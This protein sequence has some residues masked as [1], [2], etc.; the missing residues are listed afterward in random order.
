MVQETSKI[1]ETLAHGTHLRVLDESYL[2]NTIWQD[3]VVFKKYLPPCTYDES[4]L[5]IGRVKLNT[6]YWPLHIPLVMLSLLWSKAQYCTTTWDS[7]KPSKCNKIWF[8]K[9]KRYIWVNYIKNKQLLH[10][11]LTFLMLQ[12]ICF[13]RIKNWIFKIIIVSRFKRDTLLRTWSFMLVLLKVYK[14]FPTNLL[15]YSIWYSNTK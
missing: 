4:C 5:S 14:R 11:S 2:M 13:F 15:V 3:L 10:F 12:D 9:S 7:P 1:T 8:V 6:F